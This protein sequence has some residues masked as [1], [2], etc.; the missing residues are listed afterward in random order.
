M[1]VRNPDKALPL[2]ERWG[3]KTYR[4]VAELVEA[5]GG[6][7]SPTLQFVVVCVPASAN[8]AMLLELAALGVPALSQTPAAQT[9]ED[10]EMLHEQL[11]M[12][13]AKVQVAEQYLFQPMHQALLTVAASGKLGRVTHAQVAAAHGYH[14]TSLLRHY[15]GVGSEACTI[16]ATSFRAPLVVGPGRGLAM[17]AEE[18]ITQSEQTVAWLTFDCADGTQKLGI[19]DWT[20]EI[21]RSYIRATRLLVRGERGE[22]VD[23]T[24][25]YLEDPATPVEYTC[26]GVIR[27]NSPRDCLAELDIF[28]PLP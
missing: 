18:T 16:R 4:T 21:Y 20:Q 12:K 24:V 3:C 19:F 8:A 17:P 27:P 26:V 14:G 15:L 23:T 13:G 11:T 25:R 28:G 22:I 10:L 7:G 5:E 6:A 9:V 2:E 1:V